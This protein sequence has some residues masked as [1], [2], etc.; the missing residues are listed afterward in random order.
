MPVSG[1]LWRH[2]R[3]YLDSET[4]EWLS[5]YLLILAVRGGDVVHRLLTSRRNGRP[6][7]P[8]CFHEDPYPAFYLGIPGGELT[9][10][11]WLDL[12]ER[13]DFDVNYVINKSAAGDMHLVHHIGGELLCDALICAAN[14]VDTTVR[15][16][17]H[18]FATR[19]QLNCP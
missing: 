19:G 16:R 12:R 17:N 1:E 4:G 2:D 8:P 15:Q 3:F 11:S 18:I 5:K 7:A 10:D 14:C 9:R 6:Y 13:E